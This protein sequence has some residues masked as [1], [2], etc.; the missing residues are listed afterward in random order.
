MA[1]SRTVESEED[2]PLD[3]RCRRMSLTDQ[4]L[5]VAG[6]R[7]R[8]GQAFQGRGRAQAPV[9]D[10]ASRTPSR[11]G[12]PASSW[13]RHGSCRAL[14]RHDPARS[15]RGVEQFDLLVNRLLEF[16]EH[17]DDMPEISQKPLSGCAVARR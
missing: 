12:R 17:A 16:I 9:A 7:A 10:Q 1:A 13:P 3:L 2:D 11:E 15:W 4:C 5:A 8:V 6:G 14:Q